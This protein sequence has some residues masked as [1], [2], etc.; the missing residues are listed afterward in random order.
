M[1]TTEHSL[2][3]YHP[4]PKYKDLNILM[5]IVND[6]Y[7]WGQ[8]VQQHTAVA[9]LG[10]SVPKYKDH[11]Q[12]LNIYCKRS[13]YLGIVC[14]AVALLGTLSQN[15]RTVNILIGIGNDPYI[16]GHCVKQ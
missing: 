5:C 15:I 6:P 10:Y 2:D 9:L 3:T 4:V 12:Y 7:I 16:W 1:L 14:T 11:R 8:Y 13:L